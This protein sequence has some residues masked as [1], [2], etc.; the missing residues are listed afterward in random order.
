MHCALSFNRHGDNP[1]SPAE[2]P[3]FPP[4]FQDLKLHL[5]SPAV[6]VAA[7]ARPDGFQCAFSQIC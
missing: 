6:P 2:R 3:A 4:V 1:R 5:L 7:G